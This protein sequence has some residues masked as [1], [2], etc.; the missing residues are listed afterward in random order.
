MNKKRQLLFVVLFIGISYYLLKKDSYVRFYPIV[1][2]QEYDGLVIDDVNTYDRFQENLKKVL[3]YYHEDY[4]IREGVIYVKNTLYKD[5]DL[6]WNYTSKANDKV[7]LN[8]RHK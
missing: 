5:M 4:E 2:K 8:T 6:C 1:W 3:E 7:W